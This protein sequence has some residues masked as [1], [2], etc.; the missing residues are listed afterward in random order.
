MKQT[1]QQSRGNPATTNQGDKM[2]DKIKKLIVD[3]ENQIAEYDRCLEIVKNQ[4]QKLRNNFDKF[5]IMDREE[6]REERNILNAQRQRTFQFISDL[7]YL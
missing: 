6:L 5:Q 2:N 4:E 7:K 1:N 3:Y